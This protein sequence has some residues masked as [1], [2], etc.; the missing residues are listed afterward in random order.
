MEGFISLESSSIRFCSA[1]TSGAFSAARLVVSPGVFR[2]VVEL[3]L[4]RQGR[5]QAQLPVALT[6]GGPEHLDIVEISVR[7]EGAPG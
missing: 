6:Q 7:G 3:D 2:N 1:A 4:R 5:A